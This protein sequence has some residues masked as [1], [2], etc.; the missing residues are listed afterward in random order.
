M[1]DRKWSVEDEETPVGADFILFIQNSSGV[2]KLGVIST[3]PSAQIMSTRQKQ[4]DNAGA[5]LF[6]SPQGEVVGA[7]E[8]ENQMITS[9]IGILKKFRV[10][11]NSNASTINSIFTV[12]INGVDTTLTLT[13][14]GGSTTAQEIALDVAVA[15][16]DKI[17]I[18]LTGGDGFVDYLSSLEVEWG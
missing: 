12:R 9:R 3:F 13:F 5:T 18:T 14:A 6:T 17:S 8:S 1:N 16:G 2:Q 7:T 10:D 4:T 11:P 15:V